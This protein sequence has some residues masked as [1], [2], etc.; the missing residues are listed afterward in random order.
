MLQ[1]IRQM[2]V[3]SDSGAEEGGWYWIEAKWQVEC[4]WAL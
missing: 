3:G 1:D 2:W 4:V